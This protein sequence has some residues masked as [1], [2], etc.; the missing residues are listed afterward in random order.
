M[1]LVACRRSDLQS[2]W[3]VSVHRASSK[4]KVFIGSNKIFLFKMKKAEMCSIQGLW[5]DEV[6]AGLTSLVTRGRTE[7][8][9]TV[10]RGCLLLRM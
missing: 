8:K 9:S 7:V 2:H 10:R 5:K 3:S 4:P 1:V 6:G